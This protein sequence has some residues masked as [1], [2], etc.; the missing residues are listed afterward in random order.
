[1]PDRWPPGS[2]QAEN[3]VPRRYLRN[4]PA[5]NARRQATH[6]MMAGRDSV[7]GTDHRYVPSTECVSRN[8]RLR[9]NRMNSS[10]EVT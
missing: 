4:S 3:G 10:K 5:L 9:E 6:L 8:A 2:W 7:G 1:M